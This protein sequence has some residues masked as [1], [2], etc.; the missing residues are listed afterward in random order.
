MFDINTTMNGS[1][2][3]IT[4]QAINYENFPYDKLQSSYISTFYFSTKGPSHVVTMQITKHY[5]N[6]YN[7]NTSYYRL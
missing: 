5:L 7:K 6:N 1:K 2:F 3:S 4:T